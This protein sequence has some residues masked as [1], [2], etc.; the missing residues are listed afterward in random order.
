MT[1]KNAFIGYRTGGAKAAVIINP[2]NEKY[3]REI[4][5]EFGKN[6]SP[7]IK[8]GMFFPG[9]DMGI[10]PEELQIIFDSAMI[11]CDV[12]SWKNLSHEYTAY[13]CFFAT[14]CA[15]EKKNIS[16]QDVTF[17]VQGFGKVGGTYAALMSKA[18]AR[19]TAFSNKHCGVLSD[20]GFDVNE[21]LHNK[22]I[23]GDN[24]ILT[25]S[26]QKV[27]HSTVLEKDVTVLLPAAR[28][29]AINEGN[30]EKIKAEV[31]ICAANAP[32]SY[33]IERRLFQKREDSNH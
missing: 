24:F 18:G 9:M 19:L 1:Y 2:E 10:T 28:S 25:Q 3:K 33:E 5:I 4:L 30:W 22:S 21:L 31:I 6:I 8:S 7:F 11:K 13:S 14:L 16:L 23:S 29:L 12:L 32:M 17:S 15:L 26:R 20:D 27:P